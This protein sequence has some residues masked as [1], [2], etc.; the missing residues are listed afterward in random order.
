MSAET[1]DRVDTSR[2]S[3]YVD[4]GFYRELATVRAE[5]SDDWPATDLAVRHEA[6]T[7]LYREA[8]LLDEGRFNDWLDLY[9][10]ECLYWVPVA[11]SGGDPRTEV[12]HAFD[13]RRRLTD[14]VYWL[15]T[16]LAFCQI[17]QSRTRRLVGNVEVLDE[18]ERGRRRVRSTFQISEFRAGVTKA[19]AGWY[20]HVLVRTDDGWRVRLKQVNLLDSE[21]GHENMTIVF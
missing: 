2:W 20:G 11:P 1:D 17:P 7:L 13:D 5:W 18:P 10:D 4:D 6:E 15:R 16:G 19:Y 8:R 3:W 12:S 9:T 14:R 21:H